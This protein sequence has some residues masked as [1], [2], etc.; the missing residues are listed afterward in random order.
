VDVAQVE[1]VIPVLLVVPV[2]MEQWYQ[3]VTGQRVK[4]RQLFKTSLTSGTGVKIATH[5]IMYIADKGMKK[6]KKLV[7]L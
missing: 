7:I 4:R 6:R 3:L 5:T 2:E 1:P